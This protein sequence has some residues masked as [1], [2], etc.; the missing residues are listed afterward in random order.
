MVLSWAVIVEPS[1]KE[2]C[3]AQRYAPDSPDPGPAGRGRPPN[4]AP[5][6]R[7]C[8]RVPV[9]RPCRRAF[10]VVGL[11]LALA[12]GKEKPQTAD[13]GALA[14]AGSVSATDAGAPEDPALRLDDD[15]DTIANRHEGELDTDGDGVANLSDTDSDDD[16][17]P[18][19]VEAGDLDVL[20]A[21]V[22]SDGD[23][24]ADF[25][26]IDSDNDGLSDGDEVRKYGTS[27]VDADTDGDDVTDLIEIAAGSDPESRDDS[28]R[29]RG[30]FV[31]TLPYQ[32][33]PQPARSTLRFRTNIAF[34]DIYFLFDISGSMDGEIT[35]LKDA[36]GE[37]VLDLQC[38][39]TTTPCER[40]NQC[41]RG[42]ICSPFTKTCTEDPSTSSC[43]L[44]AYTGTGYYEDEYYNALSLQ[45]DPIATRNAINTDT[46]GSDEKL[47]AAVT[48]VA[49]PPISSIPTNGCIVD[50]PGL[51]G[52][53]GFRDSAVRVL[54]AFTDEKS[55][56][57]EL[58]V[59][60]RTLRDQNIRF[61]G[62]WSD[63][64]DRE[65]GDLVRLAEASGSVDSS[66]AP[67]VYDGKDSG[68]VAPVIAAVNE[69]VK[70]VPLEVRVSVS[71]VDDDGVDSTQWIQ[72]LE[73]T[74]RSTICSQIDGADVG[75]QGLPDTVDDGIP[76][77]YPEVKPGARVC[78]ELLPN[79][80]D[81][82]PPLE[83][84]QVF[85]AELTVYGDG[86]PV[87][88]RSVFFLVPPELE[89]PII[90]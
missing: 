15:G 9:G 62:V 81:G 31:F 13:P 23:G 87:D 70:G 58:E 44:S 55:A 20:T 42:E 78:W 8:L 69:I 65:R 30:D 45:P 35:A 19:R 11:G 25:V 4:D 61:V 27:P 83:T 60:A 16:G 67:M 49:D 74:K 24:R 85:K 76:D 6:A 18:D 41:A 54:V 38:R 17:V 14:D 82:V 34:A 21:P 88:T 47:Y 28:P 5:A 22:D 72:R 66:G 53:P 37:I 48:G 10:A 57:G 68:V 29:T 51:L 12:C 63:D 3:E 2:P 79:Q 90:F 7:E 39:G 84:P 73:T 40:D 50:T 46:F 59:A 1:L 75:V 33:P 56:G 89:E 86:S 80:N 52:C 26:D 64:N 43:V 36:V 77:G 32:K 71:D